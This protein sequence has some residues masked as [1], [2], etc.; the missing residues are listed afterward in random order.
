MVAITVWV[1]IKIAGGGE[2]IE[3]TTEEAKRGNL[4]Q[5][6]TATGAVA[7]ADEIDL[8]F[9]T[10]GKLVRLAVKEGNKVK[11][12][13]FLAGIDAAGLSAQAAQY[14]ASVASAQAD[15]DKIKAGSSL[16]EIQVDEEK[17][18]K[19]QNDLDTLIDKRDNELKTLREKALNEL[20]NAVFTISV[21][22]DKV[23]NYLINDSSTTD[24]QV[25]NTT[26]LN[27]LEVDYLVVLKKFNDSKIKVDLTKTDKSNESIISAADE[28]A[29]VLADLNIFLDSSFKVADSIIVN[30]TY[31]QTKKD[32]IKS[33]ITTEQSNS[34]TAITSIQTAKSNL[35]NSINSY[36]ALVQ[37]AEN[38]LSITEAQLNLTKAGPRDFEINAAQAKVAQAQAQLAK[39]L[40]DLSE[41]SLIAPIDGT[42]T[43]VNF[44]LGEQTSATSPAI[45][46]ISVE[47]FEIQ[48]DIPESD[49]AKLT[50]GDKAVIELDAFGSDYLFSGKV[51][52]IDPAQTVVQDVIYY[53][54]TVSLEA[55]EWADKIKPG[56]S[57]DVTIT[58]GQ[59][60]NIVYIPQRAVKIREASLGEVPQ[61]Y[62]EILV[63]NKVED[64]IVEIGLRGDN[65]LVEIISGI[66]EGDKVI[67]FKK[68]N[69]KK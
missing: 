23:Y 61:K 11:A 42:I 27:K 21:A 13:Q 68:T 57:A 31:T 26:L 63:N 69:G 55:N 29:M 3:Y 33:D 36:A 56:M 1:I 45:R 20:N 47:K 22:L 39:A 66:S 10:P 44:S 52:F 35:I 43:E 64:K 58:T 38:T 15:L 67:T 60:D 46:M 2:K 62:V 30:S 40:A 5:T 12:N 28:I 14:R 8:N 41:Y 34:N 6:V 19:A 49:I 37:A 59:K 54:T 7:S 17:L 32:T 25:T 16:E 9:K 18:Q 24:L 4:I 48:V 50:I 51:A 53:K 65:G